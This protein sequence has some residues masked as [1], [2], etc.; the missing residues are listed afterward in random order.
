MWLLLLLRC[1]PATKDSFTVRHTHV[2]GTLHV[3]VEQ[4]YI[5]FLVSQFNHFFRIGQSQSHLIRSFFTF[6]VSHWG[7]KNDQKK[8]LIW[9]C[10]ARRAKPAPTFYISAISMSLSM[11]F[12]IV[13]FACIR[14]A[15]N[16]S[17]R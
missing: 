15:R 10:M 5:L 2:A 9:R 7:K 13:S 12:I 1:F 17:Q 14:S 4:K 3:I 16:A 6:H 8:T 11:D